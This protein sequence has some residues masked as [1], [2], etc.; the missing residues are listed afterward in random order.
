[1]PA[2]LINSHFRLSNRHTRVAQEGQLLQ[3]GQVLQEAHL[4][5]DTYIENTTYSNFKNI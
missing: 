2:A 3:L 1:M 5:E 4:K